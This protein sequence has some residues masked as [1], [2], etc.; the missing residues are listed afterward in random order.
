MITSSVS[1]APLRGPV[2]Y[3]ASASEHLW[4]HESARTD[5]YRPRHAARLR[6]GE[7]LLAD[8][9][10]RRPVLRPVLVDVA[11]GARARARRTSST[12]YARQARESPRA[13]PIFFTTEG[14]VELAE[15]IARSTPG[16]PDRGLPD[17]LRLGGDRDR[18]QA[19]APVPPAARRPPPVQ[20][21]LALRLVPRSRDG[22]HLDR[23]PA[24]ARTPLLPARCRA[25][26]TS[27]ADRQERHR[28]RRGDPDRDRDGGP[29]D[30]RR[31]H[32]RAGRDHASSRSPTRIT[33]RA[34][35][36]SATSTGS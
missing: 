12:A 30:G 27:A 26:S 33:G 4:I 11:G 19:R 2:D 35:A 14:A 22:R 20:V 24:A 17:E 36:R 15:R 25:R 18:R 13:G 32:R 9:R 23:R 7:G 16:R 6:R 21:H 5:L 31:G 8:R 34:S 10:E 29:G 1:P 28:R 3:E